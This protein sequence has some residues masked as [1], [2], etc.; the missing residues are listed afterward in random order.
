MSEAERRGR[1]R[2]RTDGSGAEEEANS[3]LAL[4]SLVP[5]RE[6]I[7]DSREES[8]LGSSQEHTDG[9]ELTVGFDECGK[10]HDDPPQ[11][12]GREGRGAH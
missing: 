10:R 9:D 6:V 8:G 12:P 1:G 2:G 3:E 7:R 5:S 4:S 11:E